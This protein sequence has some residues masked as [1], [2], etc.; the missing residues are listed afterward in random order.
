MIAI[1]KGGTAP[2]PPA[3]DENRF[4]PETRPSCM[5]S[6][7]LDKHDDGLAILG[8]PMSDEFTWNG[9]TVQCFERARISVTAWHREDCGNDSGRGARPGGR[10]RT[11]QGQGTIS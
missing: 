9:L 4:F 11:R 6:G 7:F 1:A 3:T 8:Y 5:G 2:A 10:G